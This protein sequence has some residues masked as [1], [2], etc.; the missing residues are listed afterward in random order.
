MTQGF[1]L[2]QFLPYLLNQA[3]EATS[4]AFQPSYPGMTRTEWRVMANLGRNDGLTAAEICRTTF[5]D[6]TKVS[7]AVQALE[8]RGW[9]TRSAVKGDRRQES[10]ALS[11]A[12]RVRFY[13]IGKRAVA[14]DR[15]LRDRIGEAQAETLA[16]L[17]V[18]LMSPP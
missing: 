12:G 17:L 9:L 7:R 2:N 18:R 14:F 15:S 4:A 13:Q 1:D 6:K 16:R 10:L 3:A 11:E 8:R 5:T